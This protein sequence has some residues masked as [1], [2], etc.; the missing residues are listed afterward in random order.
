ML[1][2]LFPR[3][4]ADWAAGT[5]YVEFMLGVR[6]K[7]ETRCMAASGL[8]GPPANLTNSAAF[9]Q[10]Q[11]YGSADLPNLPLME[12]TKRTGDTIQIP[13]PPKSPAA[14]LPK[15]EQTAY[16]A[17]L[18]KCTAS[19]AKLFGFLSRG[20]A[21]ALQ[22]QWANITAQVEAEPSVRAANKKAQRCSQGTG[23]SASSVENE[24]SAIEGKSTPLNIKGERAQVL[25]SEAKGVHVLVR[26]FGPVIS[27]TTRVLTA[28]R[29]AF[30]D[31]NAPGISHL[32]DEINGTVA[33]IE[34]RYGLTPKAAEKM[35][36]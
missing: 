18:K 33:R 17:A 11:S 21:E 32:Q 2:Q 8:P 13:S 31:Q 7:T 30:F 36:Q 9:F 29:A 27:L 15:A 22:Q 19:Q 20:G 10:F 5:Q 3:S 24:I 26:C 16:N 6:F 28:R 12:R 25:A 4:G 35:K 14:A 23:F 34:K 1:A